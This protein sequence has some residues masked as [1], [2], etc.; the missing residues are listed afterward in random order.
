MK[1]K[2]G[3]ASRRSFETMPN[4]R[5]G[6]FDRKSRGNRPAWMPMK[7]KKSPSAMSEKDTG[8]PISRN[9]I[10]PANMIGAMFSTIAAP[11]SP[12]ARTAWKGEG[13]R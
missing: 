12:A 5:S 7:P 4:T 13:R 11:T 10:R 3:I 8:K 6:R 9:T 1:V 2:K